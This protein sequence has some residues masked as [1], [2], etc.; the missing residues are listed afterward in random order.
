LLVGLAQLN[1]GAFVIQLPTS[2]DAQRAKML[3]KR[4]SPTPDAKVEFEE[5][6][7]DPD[8][9]AIS[10]ITGFLSIVSMGFLFGPAAIISGGIAFSQGHKKGLIGAVLGIV[11]LTGWILAALFLVK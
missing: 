10:S 5:R 6:K 1:V 8:I 9:V 4:E 11:G 3:A 7:P 2:I